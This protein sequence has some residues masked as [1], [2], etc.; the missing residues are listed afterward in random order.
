MP[1]SE[2]EQ[3]VLEQ[4]ERALTSDDPRL[5]NT[6]Q[7]TG[8]GNALRYVLSGAGVVVGL[9]LLVVGAATSR[10]WLGAIGFVLMFAGVVF[11]FL[12][13][14]KK[15]QEGPVGVVG[16]DGTVHT[17][18]GARKPRKR[19]GGSRS[20]GFLARLEERW[21]NRRNEGGR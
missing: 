18:H 8:R 16:E 7:S 15:Q 11:A 12:G 1:L 14:R 4:M 20:G 6:L 17:P 9:L 13:P 3:R 21:E 5:A 19:Q 10:T 2:Y